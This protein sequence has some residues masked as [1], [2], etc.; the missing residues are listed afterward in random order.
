M[1]WFVTVLDGSEPRLPLIGA[2]YVRCQH[3]M[4]EI[5]IPPMQI[6]LDLFIANH[7]LNPDSCFREH[8]PS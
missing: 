4:E 5:D 2:G 8:A 1:A 6:H 7:Y 3:A